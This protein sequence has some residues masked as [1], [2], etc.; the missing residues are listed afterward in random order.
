MPPEET[1]EETVV[2]DRRAAIEAAF[3]NNNREDETQAAAPATTPEGN[4]ESGGGAS[5]DTGEVNTAGTKQPEPGAAGEDP[6]RVSE[7]GKTFPVDKAPQA[8]R[9]PQKAKWETL[10]PDVRQEVIRR[11][12]EITRTLNESAQARHFATNF[13][14]AIQPYMARIQT[15]GGDPIRAVQSL[16]A[17]DHMLST[18]PKGQRA[19]LMA[20]LINDY[21]VDVAELDAALSGQPRKNPVVDEFGQ[22]LQ[23]RLAP[24]EQFLSAQQ[25]RERQLAQQQQ[26][27]MQETIERMATDPQY[28]YFDAVRDTMADIIDIMAKKGKT[29]SLQ[30]CYNKAVA[31][32]PQVSAELAAK[33][34]AAKTAG[35]VAARNSQAQRAKQASASVSGAPS[36]KLAG[37]PVGDRRAIIAAAFEEAAGR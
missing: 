13:H 23:Q 6:P 4:D 26:A 21:G 31:M 28:P 35:Q 12:R 20:K 2:N 29:I 8:W 15:Q 3:D 18:A 10:D 16:L 17:A 36:G 32:D 19:Q 7:D 22:I 27:E 1:N 25:Q 9:G 34:E 5:A 24:I 37:A 14:Q 11:E 33:A 30:E